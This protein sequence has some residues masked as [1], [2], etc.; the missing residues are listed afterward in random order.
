VVQAIV[1]DSLDNKWFGTGD[2]GVSMFEDTAKPVQP[3]VSAISE[4]IAITDAN[5]YGLD[6]SFKV[7][8]NGSISGQY[9][10]YGIQEGENGLLNCSFDDIKMA[11]ITG[12]GTYWSNQPPDFSFFVI[13]RKDNTYA[14]I[15]IMSKTADNRFVFKY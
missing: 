11:P 9:V 12:Y 14:K 4:G 1:I 6:S 10:R 2:G 8:S 7:A 13:K 15:Q 5:G 3:P